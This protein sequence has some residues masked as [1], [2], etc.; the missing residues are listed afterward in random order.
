MIAREWRC[1]C[2]T[3]NI[4]EFIP[5]LSLTGIKDAKNTPGFKG[6]EIFKRDSGSSVEVTLITFWDSLDSVKSFAGENMERAV[7]YPDDYKYGI[8]SDLVVKH[9]TVADRF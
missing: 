5:Y 8:S 3:D 1:I 4:D 7:L 9:Y 6:A 2:P